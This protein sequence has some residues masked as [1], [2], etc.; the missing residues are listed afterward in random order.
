VVA[1]VPQRV[2]LSDVEKMVMAK[3]Y[4]DQ[5]W[6]GRGLNSGEATLTLKSQESPYLEE[7]RET[8]EG[9]DLVQAIID[10]QRREREGHW[11]F[12][13][14][15]VL[16]RTAMSNAM[17]AKQLEKEELDEKLRQRR[18]PVRLTRRQRRAQKRR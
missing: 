3:V 1:E 18:Q 12:T 5:E 9:V 11:L 16:S 14:D 6:D 17:L 2:V 10:W 4:Q 7:V 13:D 15:F 8:P